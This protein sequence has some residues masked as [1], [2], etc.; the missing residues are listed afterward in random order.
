MRIAVAGGKGGTGKTTVAVNLAAACA[1]AGRVVQYADC[2]VEMPNGRLLLQPE[3]TARTPVNVRLPAIDAARCD[4][5]GRCV[6]LCAFGALAK[7]NDRLVLF[8]E[9][10]HTCGGCAVVCPTDAI[11]EHDHEVGAVECGQAG[12]I[13]FVDGRLDIGQPRATP[14]VQA[15]KQHIDTDDDSAVAILDVAAGTSCPVI[16]AVHDADYIVLVAEPTAF[17]LHD[18]KLLYEALVELDRPAGI[19]INR[20]DIG[21]RRVQTWA[22]EHGV[23]LLATLPHDP[24][25]GTQQ[26][27]AGLA[28]HTA[29][30]LATRFD[31]LADKLMQE[32]QTCRSW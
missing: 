25:L 1:D 12:N 31:A 28:Y 26:A 4:L 7:L 2:D 24:R 6:E 10:C 9:L 27:T 23:P 30:D 17:G 19:V 3:I 15:V 32:V 8:D 16:E 18:L 14:V 20:A 13:A 29:A 11:S 22:A 5:C 21:D